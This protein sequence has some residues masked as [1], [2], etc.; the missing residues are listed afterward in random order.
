MYREHQHF[1]HQID[2]M[3]VAVFN[4]N[5]TYHQFVRQFNKIQNDLIQVYQTTILF[6][7]D[8]DQQQVIL[9]FEK[10]QIKITINVFQQ[11]T[12]CRI[13]TQNDHRTKIKCVRT[14]I[15]II[16]RFIFITMNEIEMIFDEKIDVYVI[17]ND[18]QLIVNR[19]V[20]HNEQ[21]RQIVFIF[22]CYKNRINQLK[23]NKQRFL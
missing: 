6:Q 3:N 17:L 9:K 4:N 1:R 19:V 5:K 15:I 18:S 23:E 2:Q 22:Q 11:E 13:R 16:T 10:N 20:D 8:F 7:I 14:L 21:L 12:N